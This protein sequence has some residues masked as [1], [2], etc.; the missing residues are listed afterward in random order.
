M[1]KT[2]NPEN[3]TNE[4]TETISPG[5]REKPEVRDF[6]PEI[7]NAFIEKVRQGIDRFV[8]EGGNT[9][10]FDWDGTIRGNN[11]ENGVNNYIR[12]AFVE[13]YAY[14]REHGLRVGVCSLRSLDEI[15][16]LAH[17][18]ITFDEYNGADSMTAYIATHPSMFHEAAAE[19][20][21]LPMAEVT[22]I[23]LDFIERIKAGQRPEGWEVLLQASGEM[24]ADNPAYINMKNLFMAHR[25]SAGE[26]VFL[27]D[28]DGGSGGTAEKF[29]LGVLV[30][31]PA[32][33]THDR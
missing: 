26:K 13:S 25:L 12:R 10:L 8:K 5:E 1:A 29:G 15:E 17:L 23:G 21:K 19:F 2:E 22:R 4:N 31:K 20:K 7:E 32:G 24:Q 14:A 16:N 33:Y 3:E 27:I 11:F 18:G 9:V 6:D 30:P 28:D